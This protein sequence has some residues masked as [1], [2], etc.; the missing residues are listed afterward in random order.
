MSCCSILMSRKRFVARI[1]EYMVIPADFIP[2][3]HRSLGI[4]LMLH[5]YPECLS[6]SN[7]RFGNR[8]R[9]S[10]LFAQLRADSYSIDISPWL[11]STLAFQHLGF[12][13]LWHP[14]ILDFALIPCLKGQPFHLFP[15]AHIWCFPALVLVVICILFQT[16]RSTYEIQMIPVAI[17]V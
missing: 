13:A 15:F 12:P 1:L 4:V 3:R 16:P 6:F 17:K 8:V 7:C 11:S 10:S 2:S 14:G 5:G 9:Y